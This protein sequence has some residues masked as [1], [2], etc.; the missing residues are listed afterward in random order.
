MSRIIPHHSIFIETGCLSQTQSSL[1][2]LVL[3]ASLLSV[4]GIQRSALFM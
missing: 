2:W 4:I 1:I 3:L